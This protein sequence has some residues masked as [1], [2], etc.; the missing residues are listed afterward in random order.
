M[1][2]ERRIDGARGGKGV[3]V[4][5][6]RKNDSSPDEDR[7]GLVSPPPPVLLPLPARAARVPVDSLPLLS[8]RGTSKQ[9]CC[10]QMAPSEMDGLVSGIQ[11]CVHTWKGGQHGANLRGKI[12]ETDLCGVLVSAEVEAG[13][14]AASTELIR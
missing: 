5:R 2:P 14:P 13:P 9:G 6:R 4:W 3:E 10:S 7:S 12:H 11:A 8:G 1:A